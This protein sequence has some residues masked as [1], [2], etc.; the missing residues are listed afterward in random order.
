M[1]DQLYEYLNENSLLSHHQFSFRKFHSNASALLDCTNSLYMNM[2]RKMFNLVVFLDLKKAFDT[3]NHDILVRK[4][5]LFGITGNALS[6]I[7]YFLTDRKQKC[8]LGDVITSESSVTCGIP[9][10]SIL[11]PLLFV[12][13]INDLPDCLRQVSRRLFADDTNLTV[14]G[15]TIEEV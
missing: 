1:Y 14:A 15:E 10:G 6:M 3:V 11:G 7:K 8:Q 2:D 9:Q 5:E 12:L 4:L 13:Y